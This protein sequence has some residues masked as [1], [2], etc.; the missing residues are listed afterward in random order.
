MGSV[1]KVTCKWFK[2]VEDTS[3]PR[4]DFIENYNE[5]SDEGYFLEVDV[6][7]LQNIHNLNN[8]LPLLP[9]RTK[10]EKNEKLVGNLHN[11]KEYIIHMNSSKQALNHG[12]VLE[13]QSK[14]NQK[15]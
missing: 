2:W 13:S 15:A 14:V 8:D 10:I 5:D 3:Q 6:Q 11:K 4:K 1:T 12:L 9:E 7:C